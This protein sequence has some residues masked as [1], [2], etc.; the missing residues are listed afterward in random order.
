MKNLILS[1]LISASTVSASFAMDLNS[2]LNAAVKNNFDIKSGTYRAEAKRFAAE[3]YKS[4]YYP[5][6]DAA[7]QYADSTEKAYNKFLTKQFSSIG[8][9]LTYNLFNGFSD[10]YNYLSAEKE[11]SAEKYNTEA[12][13]QDIILS[14]KKAYIGIL[15]A[16]DNVTVAK[17]AVSL[18]ENQLADTKLFFKAGLV[19]RN[20]LLKVE[21]EL[22]SA[23]QTQMNAE[24]AYKVSVFNLEKLTGLEIPTT[25]TFADMPDNDNTID[26]IAVLKKD[27]ISNRSELKYLLDQADA[28]NLSKE[29]VLGGYL[30]KVNVG[31]AHYSYGQDYE[32]ADR[33][34][35]YDNETIFS[36]SV[37][38]NLFDGAR[39]AKQISAKDAEKTAL[40][41]Q[42]K[43][44]ESSMDLQLKTAVENLNLA[45]NSMIT[46]DSEVASAK[47]NYRI[48]VDQY[49]QKVATNTDMINARVMLTRAETDYNNAKH[50]V[51]SALAD[52]D[53]ITERK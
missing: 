4:S 9:S 24:S 40:I 33:T 1:V 39:K 23:T 48:T 28:I 36:A 19:A 20:E 25:E 31:V 18:L 11:Y 32:P 2:A 27:M 34:H 17:E 3:S 50:S 29:A 42:I 44:T 45:K 46:A 51:Q 35:M 52:I 38:I 30:P 12:V 8:I 14:V 41:Y 37:S 6:A 26:D 43:N 7:Y 47:E 16:K 21:S 5:Q 49:K 22:A 10:K 13:K 15:N 53:R